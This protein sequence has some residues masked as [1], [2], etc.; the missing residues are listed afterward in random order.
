M[1]RCRCVD[2]VGARFAACAAVVADAAAGFAAIRVTVVVVQ[3]CAVSLS[4]GA[5]GA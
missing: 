5:A 3:R 1:C 2:A 4:F